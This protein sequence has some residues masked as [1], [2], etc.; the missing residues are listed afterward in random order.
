METPFAGMVEIDAGAKVA[1]QWVDDQQASMGSLQRILEGRCIA[2]T[3]D[4]DWPEPPE[5]TPRN[6]TRRAASPPSFAKR[7]R[8][9]SE[10]AFSVEA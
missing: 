8:P 5:T 3:S 10:P 7:G 4:V 2:E 6:N 1:V 9:T